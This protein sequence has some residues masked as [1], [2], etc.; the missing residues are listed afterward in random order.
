MTHEEFIELVEKEKARQAAMTPE[1]L[2][3]VTDEG[4]CA[5]PNEDQDDFD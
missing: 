4:L 3:A 2:D 5:V 1:E